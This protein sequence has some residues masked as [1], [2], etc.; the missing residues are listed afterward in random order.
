MMLDR[1]EDKI[2]NILFLIK[3]KKKKDEKTNEEI[4]F[5]ALTHGGNNSTKVDEKRKEMTDN[6]RGWRPLNFIIYVLAQ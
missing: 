3:K 4:Y 6:T 2:R 1:R 5:S